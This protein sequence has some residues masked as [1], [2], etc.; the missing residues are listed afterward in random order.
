[1]ASDLGAP[2]NSVARTIGFIIGFLSSI[3]GWILLIGGGLIAVTAG[4]HTHAPNG[5]SLLGLI[6]ALWGAWLLW[7]RRD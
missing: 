3:G 2:V 1:M 5:G 4:M 7:P 6:L